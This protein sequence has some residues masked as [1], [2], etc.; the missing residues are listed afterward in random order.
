MSAFSVK[1]WSKCMFIVIEAVQILVPVHSGI[2][3]GV[4]YLIFIVLSVIM[5]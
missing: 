1:F 2:E 4:F 3:S 5:C